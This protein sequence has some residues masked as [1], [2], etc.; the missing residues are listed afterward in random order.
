MHYYIHKRGFKQEKK[1]QVKENAKK[2]VDAKQL[3]WKFSSAGCKSVE[4]WGS[5]YFILLTAGKL[6]FLLFLRVL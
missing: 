6:I 1:R 3:K 2:N 5:F 4:L